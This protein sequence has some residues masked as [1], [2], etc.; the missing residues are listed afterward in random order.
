[1]TL[2][3]GESFHQLLRSVE[4]DFAIFLRSLGM[5]EGLSLGKSREKCVYIG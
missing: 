2:N 3:S 1:M 4:G 5:I